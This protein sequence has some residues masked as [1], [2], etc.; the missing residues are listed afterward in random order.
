MFIHNL[1]N[2]LVQI[3][4]K[5]GLQK[6]KQ[7]YVYL[8]IKFNPKDVTTPLTALTGPDYVGTL[9]KLQGSSFCFKLRLPAPNCCLQLK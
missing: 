8:P 6:K 4:N 3:A 5:M 1:L 7:G 2:V 9:I